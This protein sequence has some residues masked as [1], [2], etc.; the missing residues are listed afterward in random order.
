M[1]LPAGRK[2]RFRAG[3]VSAS[4]GPTLCRWCHVPVPRMITVVFILAALCLLIVT[5]QFVR[6]VPIR[7]KRRD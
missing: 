5:E 2:R 3:G 1:D 4:S 6:P 7:R